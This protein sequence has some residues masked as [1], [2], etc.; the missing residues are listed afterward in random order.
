MV[1]S[2]AEA[3]AWQHRGNQQSA[4]SPSGSMSVAGVHGGGDGSGSHFATQKTS[5]GKLGPEQEAA[6]TETVEKL[7]DMIVAAENKLDKAY[8]VCQEKVALLTDG[9]DQTWSDIVTLGNAISYEDSV[10]KA[11]LNRVDNTK[12]SQEKGRDLLE[13][14]EDKH[15]EVDLLKKQLEQAKTDAEV[16]VFLLN[17]TKSENCSIIEK[18]KEIAGVA[19]NATPP[20]ASL[21]QRRARATSY[22]IC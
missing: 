13:D 4:A 21:L 18:A 14:L 20:S 3:V 22:Q 11:A 9:H 2:V 7:N 15:E 6:V 17:Y 8:L 16:G 5:R 1:L 10:W 12:D 19:K